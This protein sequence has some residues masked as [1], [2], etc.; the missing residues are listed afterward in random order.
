MFFAFVKENSSKGQE[1][2]SS[3]LSIPWLCRKVPAGVVGLPRACFAPASPPDLEGCFWVRPFHGFLC[4]VLKQRQQQPLAL[5]SGGGSPWPQFALCCCAADHPDPIGA[6]LL[7]ASR[8]HLPPGVDGDP[9]SENFRAET[10][11][12]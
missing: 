2:G 8:L 9:E 6:G 5:G 12:S 10:S 3:A 11:G 7:S 1:G 4:F